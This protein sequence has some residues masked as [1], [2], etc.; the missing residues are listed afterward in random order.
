MK[1]AKFELSFIWPPF[2]LPFFLPISYLPS[3]GSRVTLGPRDITQ[4]QI[5]ELDG[6]YVV[7][8]LIVQHDLSLKEICGSVV[9]EDWESVEVLDYK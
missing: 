9:Q 5:K 1:N 8:N 4:D 3:P 6:L 2:Q 7:S